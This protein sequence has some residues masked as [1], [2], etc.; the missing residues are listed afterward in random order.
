MEVLWCISSLACHVST[1]RVSA[2]SPSIISSCC[3]QTHQHDCSEWPPWVQLLC[4]ISS[5]RVCLVR[6]RC[7][8]PK[9]KGFSW[10]RCQNNQF[11]DKYS[12]WIA[13]L[14][15][16]IQT[17]TYEKES[18]RCQASHQ[19]GDCFTKSGTSY[20][21]IESVVVSASVWQV[22]ITICAFTQLCSSLLLDIM[23]TSSI[24]VQS[25]VSG[26]P[27]WAYCL[28]ARCYEQ[29]GPWHV[30]LIPA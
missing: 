22:C 28:C 12:H 2:K 23:T 10:H 27:W 4:T 19:G 8:H 7:G 29:E 5:T 1:Y 11:L 17:D 21:W 24:V 30:H 26:T 14:Q 3:N 25:R 9:F 15:S 13:L 6:S 16:S 18:W 20:H